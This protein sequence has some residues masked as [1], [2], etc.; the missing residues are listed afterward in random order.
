M[1]KIF[2]S[3]SLAA[4][5]AGYVAYQRIVGFGGST[6]Y[7]AQPPVANNMPPASTPFAPVPEQPVVNPT[8]VPKI[9]RLRYGEDDF[10]ES[11]DGGFRRVLRTPVAITPAPVV[12]NSAPSPVSITTAPTP[13]TVV[14][15]IGLYK[16]GAYTS[17]VTD[18][19][20][21]NVQIKVTISNG[22]ISDVQFLDYP[23]DRGT[24]VRINNYATPI[25]ASEAIQG[26]SANVDA[27]SGATATS[28]AFVE[29]LSGV[30]AN[31][32]N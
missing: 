9:S 11:D 16:N 15:N 13:A 5:F 7:V 1:K 6:I 12:Q 2:L 18:A 21:G 8:P 25:L 30:L 27:V 22:R 28:G 10:E 29:A 20:Y 23:Q 4:L 3:L 17:A 24:S 31:A 19:Y 14:S 26:Q 32:K